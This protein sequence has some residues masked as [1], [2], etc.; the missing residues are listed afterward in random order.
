MTATRMWEVVAAPGRLDDLV[1]WPLGA[2]PST[3]AVYR[4]AD[5]RVVV[6]DPAGLAPGDPPPDLVTRPPHTWE[7]HPVSR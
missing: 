7:F 5:T 4:S 3:A 1:A 2:A 6:I